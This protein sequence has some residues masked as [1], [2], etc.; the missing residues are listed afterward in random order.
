MATQ[1]EVAD[2]LGITQGR[3]SQLIRKGILPP[4]APGDYSLSTML[5]CY[6]VWQEHLQECYNLSISNSEVITYWFE[7]KLHAA[8]YGGG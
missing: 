4:A 5:W 7:K 3:V 2:Y 6:E 1:K 8:H